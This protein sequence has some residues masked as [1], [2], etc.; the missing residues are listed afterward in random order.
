VDER[1]IEIMKLRYFLGVLLGVNE[2]IDAREPAPFSFEDLY[3][4]AED[5]RVMPLLESHHP[6]GQLGAMAYILRDEG[7]AAFEDA[8]YYAYTAL[9]G[10][11]IRKTGVGDNP[12]CMVVA[13]VLEAIQ[14][15]FPMGA[16]PK[17]RQGDA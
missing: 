17:D 6:Q 4:A 7:G 3:R 14:N 5:R 8:L 1:L 13:I 15:N 10:Q 12:W 11:E 2:A 9:E 16:P